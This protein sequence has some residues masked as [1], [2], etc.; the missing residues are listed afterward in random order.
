MEQTR[1]MGV[2]VRHME[3]VAT[4][5]VLQDMKLEIIQRVGTA[6]L[7]LMLGRDMA[8]LLAPPAVDTL[9]QTPISPTVNQV[10][11]SF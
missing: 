11:S 2:E 10:S 9:N 5:V 6:N 7:F 4:Q 1:Q 3:E 8:R